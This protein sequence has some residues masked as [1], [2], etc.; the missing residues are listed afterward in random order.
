MLRAEDTPGATGEKGRP[1]LKDAAVGSAERSALAGDPGGRRKRARSRERSGSSMRAAGGY[2]YS[3]RLPSRMRQ[4]VRSR[5]TVG[6]GMRKEGKVKGLPS[7]AMAAM[8]GAGMIDDSR[9]RGSS[10]WRR[11]GWAIYTRGVAHLN[12][13]LFRPPQRLS[14]RG[15]SPRRRGSGLS[16][17]AA[18]DA[19]QHGFP[20]RLWKSE[21]RLRLAGPPHARRNGAPYGRGAGGES[22]PHLL[23]AGAARGRAKGDRGRDTLCSPC[24]EV[25]LTTVIPA[26]FIVQ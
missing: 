8:A 11:R 12:G 16:R 22:D 9:L 14:L 26:D 20:I 1:P 21:G 3:M 15:R 18:S 7:N 24:G 23:A 10:S 17:N 4:R 19:G 13:P 2:C 6:E 25:A 5:A